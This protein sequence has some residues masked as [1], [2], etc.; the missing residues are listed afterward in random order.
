MKS[1]G[2]DFNP[3]GL[4]QNQGENALDEIKCHIIGV[5]YFSAPLLIGQ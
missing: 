1:N 4:H 5:H 2:H 3:T